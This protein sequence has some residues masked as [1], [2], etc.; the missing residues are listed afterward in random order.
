MLARKWR[1]K[2]FDEL[3]GQE[4]V[5]RALINAIEQERLHHAYL[6]TG[7]RGVGKTTIARILSKCLNC[8]THGLTAKPCGECG[9]CVE[10][11]EGRFVD[12]IEVDAASRTKVDDTRELLDNVQYRPTRGRYKVY[13]IDEVHM[14]SNSSF[15]A[16][17]KTLE[18]PPEHV[19]FL[20]ATTDPQK[21][22]VTVLSRCLQ[23]HLKHMDEAT[24]ANHLAFILQ[25]EQLEFEQTALSLI[26]QSAEGS[27]RDA[28]SLL[29][30]AIAFGQGQVNEADIRS[31]LGTID[32]QFMERLLQAL[33]DKDAKQAIESIAQMSNFPVDFADALKELLSRLHQVAIFQATGVLLDNSATY[34]EKFAQQISAEDLQ[35]Y[36]QL[37]LHA[38]RDLTWAATPKQGL[39]MALLR[40]LAFNIAPITDGSNATNTASEA[41]K[42]K[43]SL[44][45]AKVVKEAEQTPEKVPQKEL[46]KESNKQVEIKTT[47]SE[48]AKV[49]VAKQSAPQESVSSDEPQPNYDDYVWG[50]ESEGEQAETYPLETAKDTD[51]HKP[52]IQD[53]QVST[54]SQQAAEPLAISKKVKKTE[55]KQYDPLASLHA[56]LG[57]S[58]VEK[59]SSSQ[60]TSSSNANSGNKSRG[61]ALSNKAV[62]DELEETTKNPLDL[63]AIKDIELPEQAAFDQENFYDESLDE[64][65]LAEHI[66]SQTQTSDL[67]Q[68]TV[69]TAS[70]S[71]N[72]S[73]VSSTDDMLAKDLAD[74]T[75]EWTQ[76]VIKL[77][78]PGSYHQIAQSSLMDWQQ[79]DLMA[80]RVA[81]NQDILC[82]DSA[83]AG[84]EKAIIEFFDRRIRFQWSFAEPDRETPAMIFARKAEEKQQNA[85]DLL[86]RH[87]FSQ[88]L[89]QNF[90]AK[91][92]PE[93]IKYLD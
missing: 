58:S 66:Y 26:A 21:L 41:V 89:A 90:A 39:E 38:R 33:A 62:E 31:M 78:L 43:A 64:Q 9:A 56:A 50:D 46:G 23:F 4:H 7:T 67:A 87:P 11:D 69:N 8:E 52:E 3:Q 36:Y 25:Q 35:L 73:S 57:I 68:Q 51:S 42:K 88:R 79:E 81:P 34:V 55:E 37:G 17:L 83:K 2:N 80:L 86:T 93:T 1:P 30:Q 59:Q 71:A 45:D 16:L 20:L 14:L 77:G 47:E 74:V 29:D 60:A 84:I 82:T 10:I 18:E 72:E 75:D 91:L 44:V 49:K 48:A 40:M 24:I 53:E 32:H 76:L 92:D 28:L 22:P 19:I 61:L 5:S 15:N 6:F 27:M 63:A 85:C 13:L 12:L 70:N 54:T 65:S